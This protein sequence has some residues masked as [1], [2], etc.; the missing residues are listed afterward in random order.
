MASNNNT[1]HSPA[2]P[3]GLRQSYT[4]SSSDTSLTPTLSPEH[5]RSDPS[6]NIP[7]SDTHTNP[8]PRPVNPRP[9]S[10]TTALLSESLHGDHAHE[11]PC[12]HGT[13]PP[14]PISPSTSFGYGPNNFSHNA[15]RAPS[16]G[17]SSQN[18]LPIVDSVLAFVAAKGAP[19]WR[20][21]W[22]RKMRSKTMS[23]SSELAERHGV[24]DSGFM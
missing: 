9:A 20:K 14:R 24:K 10:E 19:D 2:T 6:Q 15:S 3:S 12:D 21:R 18:S 7:E 13:F 8:R 16:P 1:N 23:T 17:A 4:A 5:T 22:A 11:G